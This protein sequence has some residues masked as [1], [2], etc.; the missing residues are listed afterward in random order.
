MSI[1]VNVRQVVD[2]LAFIALYSIK[3]KNVSTI[4][5]T[6]VVSLFHFPLLDALAASSSATRRCVSLTRERRQRGG[7]VTC[8][9]AMIYPRTSTL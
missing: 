7:N 1:G 6:F 2:I 8:M 4:L 9:Y 5:F 3:Q